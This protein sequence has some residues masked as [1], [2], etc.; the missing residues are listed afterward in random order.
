MVDTHL[1]LSTARVA[2]AALAGTI[3]LVAARVYVGGRQRSILILAAGT[4]LLAAGYFVEGLL[5][6][7]AGW[8]VADATVLEAVTT[9]VAAATLVASIYVRD[10]RPARLRH[11]PVP[12]TREVR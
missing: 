11:A 7:L 9:L 12:L 8:S 10:S 4:G 6:E 3:S 2:T 1:I 5:V